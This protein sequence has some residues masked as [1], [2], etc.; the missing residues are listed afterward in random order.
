[1]V[2]NQSSLLWFLFSLCNP[3]VL[4]PTS[5]GMNIRGHQEWKLQLLLRAKRIQ[6]PL[7][8]WYIFLKTHVLPIWS[9]IQFSLTLYSI[10]T[11]SINLISFLT[12]R[13]MKI[14]SHSLLY[15]QTANRTYNIS[16]ARLFL[17]HFAWCLI[18]YFL[19]IFKYFQIDN[20]KGMQWTK[21]L[22]HTVTVLE[23]NLGYHQKV[24]IWP[25]CLIPHMHEFM[26]N[27]SCDKH[28]FYEKTCSKASKTKTK[29]I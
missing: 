7:L 15:P 9:K 25:T 2:M 12:R 28:Y 5:Y 24:M 22:L 11:I 19:S 20:L 21:R 4:S 10:S 14:L 3:Y 8:L 27:W 18:N 29:K 13:R 26:K 16:L 1:M 6:S 23:F 17:A